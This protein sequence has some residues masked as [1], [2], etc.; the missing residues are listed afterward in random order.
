MTIIAA[1]ALLP[2]GKI[3]I[4]GTFATRFFITAL[5]EHALRDNSG[6]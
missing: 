4:A 6:G 5:R 1:D 3:E 2:H